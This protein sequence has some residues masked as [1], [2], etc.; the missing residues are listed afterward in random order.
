MCGVWSNGMSLEIIEAYP[1]T[2]TYS[3]TIEN[4]RSKE[5]RDVPKYG[6]TYEDIDKKDA[7]TCALV[8]HLYKSNC[9]KYLIGPGGNVPIEEGWIWVPKDALLGDLR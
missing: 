1:S 4:F 6:E 7:L 8:A 9:K 3:G 2:C 5:C